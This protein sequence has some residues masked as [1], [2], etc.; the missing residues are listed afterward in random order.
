MWTTSEQ[1]FR[2]AEDFAAR[3]RLLKDEPMVALALERAAEAT[4][5]K[6]Q[7]IGIIER[8]LESLDK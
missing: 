6:A 2:H 5:K 7:A 4:R 1:E 3:A 8:F